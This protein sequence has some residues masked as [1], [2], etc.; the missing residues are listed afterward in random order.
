MNLMIQH[1]FSFVVRFFRLCVFSL[2]L[3]LIPYGTL[4]AQQ[5]IET[6]YTPEESRILLRSELSEFEDY[7]ETTMNNA[8]RILKDRGVAS[9]DLKK[10][11][12]WQQTQQERFHQALAQQN[13][14]V[15][16]VDAWAVGKSLI[17]CMDQ[18]ESL[19]ELPPSTRDVALNM[20][21]LRADRLAHVAS[22]YLSEDAIAEISRQLDNYRKDQPIPKSEVL[23]PN[24]RSWS[25][26][27]FSAWSMG[28]SGV[29]SLLD[30][31][32]MPGRALQGVSDS[33]KALTG[34]R[35]NTEDAVRVAEELPGRIRREF[36]IA[37]DDLINKRSEILEMVNAINSVSTNF[38]ATAS[39]T[40]L[41]A[42]EIQKS[43]KLTNEMLPEGQALVD[44]VEQTIESGKEL[45][46]EI[47]Q[48][49]AEEG[50]DG[51]V[52]GGRRERFDI[53]EYKV[54]ADS[55]TSAAAE[56]RQ[57]L[58]EIRPL[59]EPDSDTDLTENK[60]RFDI[61]D[62]DKAAQSVERGAAEIRSLL[63]DLQ[64]LSEEDASSSGIARQS[65]EVVDHIT[66]RVI[67][68]VALMFFLACVY[69]VLKSKL[70]S[71]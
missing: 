21:K 20:L 49:T 30:L 11:D 31:P 5:K 13:P 43:L 71:K 15:A 69:L 22:R 27:L 64:A 35:E 53:A 42:V 47:D 32:L 19:G 10:F 41:T 61:R 67:Q 66:L 70:Q 38:R 59:V 51:S 62:Y 24:S 37:L 18:R 65:R 2:Y 63:K 48:L 14:V 58:A 9:A 12:L 33:G 50:S 29:E 25:S 17:T 23:E 7:V 56:V 16:L 6:D 8:Q 44:A 60:D 4:L 52:Q 3:F 28:K 55:V 57:M 40:Q 1:D 39:S 46:R 54:A 34:I 45:I 26:P 36:Q 68:V